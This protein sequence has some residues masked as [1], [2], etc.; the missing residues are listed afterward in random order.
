[1]L[2]PQGGPGIYERRAHPNGYWLILEMIM[3]VRKSG[4]CLCSAADD[5][6]MCDCLSGRPG[7][8]ALAL[9]HGET[10]GKLEIAV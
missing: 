10:H 7:P 4:V 3:N 9:E 2:R 8:S 6:G 1:M 5:E